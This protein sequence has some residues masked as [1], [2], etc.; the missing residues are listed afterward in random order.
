[1]EARWSMSFL[2]EVEWLGSKAVRVSLIA[3]GVILFLIVALLVGSLFTNGLIRGRAENAMNEKLVGYHSKVA[4][5]RL[6]LLDGNLTLMGVTVVQ[7]AY[8]TP[9]VM[10]IGSN[11]A[12]LDWG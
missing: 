2:S 12:Q 9:P 11:R 8:P 4:R 6:N 10:R 1:L 7:N 5:A 3:L